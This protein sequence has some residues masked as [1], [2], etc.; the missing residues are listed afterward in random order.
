MKFFGKKE[1]S[2]LHT[3]YAAQDRRRADRPFSSQRQAARRSY[4]TISTG[5]PT[6]TSFTR[7]SAS[8]FASRKQPWDSVRPTNSGLGVP[9]IP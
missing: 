6:Q 5:M 4:G 3:A 2:Q 1:I 7:Y 8:Q 9:C